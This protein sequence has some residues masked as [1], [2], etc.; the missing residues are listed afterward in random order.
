[1]T[2][3]NLGADPS[4]TTSQKLSN[5]RLPVLKAPGPDSNYLDWELV[6]MA[7]LEAAN[8]DYVVTKP[9]PEKPP[10]SWKANNKFTEA[11]VSALKNEHTCRQSQLDA[12]I[13]VSLA[14]AK[15]SQ[16][17]HGGE[18]SKKPRHCVFCNP[19]G[20]DLNNCYNTRRI[21]NEHKANQKPRLDAKDPSKYLSTPAARAGKTTTTSLGDHAD[22][23]D[24][25][26][27]EL[28]AKHLH[29]PLPFHVEVP[30]PR[31]ALPLKL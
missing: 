14:K 3:I 13:T 11:I 24:Y 2:S 17:K 9:M 23:S 7:Y 31:K 26:G 28:E 22:E 6:V 18:T 21:L 20:H 1:S 5:A 25:S 15:P 29:P 12:L 19:N 8:I 30:W 27:S 4:S 16:T 10:D